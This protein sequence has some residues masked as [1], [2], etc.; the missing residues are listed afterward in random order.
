MSAEVVRFASIQPPTDSQVVSALMFHEP[1]Q[2][3]PS[4]HLERIRPVM[5]RSSRLVAVL[6]F[7][8]T[9]CPGVDA[10]P[11]HGPHRGR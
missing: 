8:L 11:N 6:R 2:R 1:Y 5:N 7:A 9:L 10:A 3:G 4:H